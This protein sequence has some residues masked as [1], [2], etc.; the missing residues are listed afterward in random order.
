VW[1]GSVE[2]HGQPAQ[3][4]LRLKV[5]GG[6]IAEA[7][8]VISRK[9]VDNG[10]Y[11]D[12]SK[13]V[14]E[15]AFAQEVP[16]GQRSS[17]AELIKLADGYFSTL[18]RNDGTIRTKFDPQCARKENGQSTTDGSFASSPPGCEAQFKLGWFKYDNRVRARRYIADEEHGVVVATGYIDYA[19]DFLNFKTMDG[20]DATSP[21][22]F[23]NSLGFM[24]MFKIVGGRIYRIESVFTTLPYYMPSPWVDK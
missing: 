24:E 11:G 4:A 12:A 6:A 9:G 5:E 14:N 3:V 19:A 18:Q 23:P 8:T 1:Y 15:P 7:E 10:P 16:K 22:T 2:E 13:Y 17:R 21:F 20:K